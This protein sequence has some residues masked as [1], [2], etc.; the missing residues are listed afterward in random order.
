MLHRN[1]KFIEEDTF[2][3]GYNPQKEW[4]WLITTAFFL[5]EVGAGLFLVSLFLTGKISLWSSIV[6]WLI[7][8]AG[9]N[10]AHFI[11]LGKPW[12]FWRMVFRPQTSWISRGFFATGA[13]MVFGFFHI[14]FASQEIVNPL[15]SVV[16][17]LAGFSAFVVM[18]YDGIVMTYSPSLPLWN[19]S[20]LPILRLSYALMGGV[21]LSL[22][23]SALPQLAA[24]PLLATEAHVLEG[25][26]RWL[27]IVNLVMIVVYILTLTY[28][29]ATAKESAY[30]IVREKYPVVFWFGVVLVGLVV[31]FLL[32]VIVTTHNLSLLISVAICELIGDFCILFLLIRSGVYSPLMPHPNIDPTLFSQMRA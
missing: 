16:M 29:V 24:A 9:K 8:T 31:I 21:T 15:S 14:V 23:I 2:E 4:A 6:G 11:Y 19:N 12:R 3:V 17:W 28:S 26:E 7:V 30:L 13:L 5:G 27:I 22:L 32:P 10:T 1:F 18:I 20:L 25:L